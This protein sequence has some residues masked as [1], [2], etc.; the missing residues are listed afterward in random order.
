MTQGWT[1]SQVPIPEPIG[2][3]V[4]R[5]RWHHTG[6]IHWRYAPHVLAPLIPAG[7]AVDVLD[8][9]AWV[10]LVMFR[11]E[12]TRLPGLPPVPPLSTFTEINLRTYVTAPGDRPALWFFSLEAP[13][14]V[15]V[16][17]ARLM[18]GVPYYLARTSLEERDG[19]IEYRSSRLPSGASL[20]ARIR[21]GPPCRPEEL[22]PL[23]HFLTARWGAY[24]LVLGSLRYNPVEHPLWPLHAAEL[25]ELDESL[26]DAA[27]LPPPDHPPLVQYAT[28]LEAT[29]GLHRRAGPR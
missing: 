22:T 27:R 24:S 10:S 9:S 16:A 4:L 13:Q 8:G 20:R 25:V 15:L 17:G 5:Q 18:A 6:F 28:E 23:D 2:L 11:C 7:L 12:R 29:I 21:A 26:V 1:G 14:P 3:P 19:E